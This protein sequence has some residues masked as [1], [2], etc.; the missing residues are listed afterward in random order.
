MSETSG[1]WH[2]GDEEDGT[3]APTEEIRYTYTVF[4]DGNVTLTNIV[5]TDE[6]IGETVCSEARVAPGESFTC[7]DHA[8][9]VSDSDK[10]TQ[11]RPT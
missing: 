11:K 9:T 2:D 10:T 5:V 1:R 7:S 3:A 8:Y 4:N 6:N